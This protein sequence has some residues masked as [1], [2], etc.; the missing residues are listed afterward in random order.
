MRR[1]SRRAHRN[2]VVAWDEALRMVDDGTIE[3]AK[4][5]VALLDY[6]RVRS[7]G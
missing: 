5:L 6:D 1:S 4:T 7:G 2:L 3:D